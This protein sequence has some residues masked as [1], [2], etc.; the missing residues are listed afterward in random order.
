MIIR[1]R[2]AAELRDPELI[3]HVITSYSIHYTK[4]YDAPAAAKIERDPSALQALY[5]A[6]KKIG[7]ANDL[8]Q[9]LI[10][11][12]DAALYLVP[13]ATHVTIVLRDDDQG[14]DTAASA[15]VPVMTRVRFSSGVV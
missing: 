8:D 9:V 7:A 13:S 11:V 2:H 14:S 15:F 5:V 4:L 1:V 12:A 6:Q 3:D 10:E